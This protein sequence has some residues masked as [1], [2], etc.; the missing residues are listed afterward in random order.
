MAR[1]LALIAIFFL[2]STAVAQTHQRGQ[3]TQ[4]QS[5]YLAGGQPQRSSLQG[6][7]RQQQQQRETFQNVF[8]AFDENLMAEAFNVP[9]EVIRRMQQEDER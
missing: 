3:Q 7:P 2:V 9:V 8:R 5:F 6:S 1:M 4:Q